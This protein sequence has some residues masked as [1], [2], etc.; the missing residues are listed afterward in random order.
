MANG[1]GGRHTLVW[2]AKT[3]GFALAV[4]QILSNWPGFIVS[5]TPT[6][7]SSGLNNG[8]TRPS[9]KSAQRQK[10]EETLKTSAGTGIYEA[11]R[12]AGKPAFILLTR[13]IHSGLK[14]V[15]VD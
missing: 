6:V 15:E 3:D 2:P 9:R 4:Q 11:E 1:T 14:W 7:P 12:K 5:V 10:S 13:E 8:Q